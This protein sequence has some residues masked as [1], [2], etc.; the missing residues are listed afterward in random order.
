MGRRECRPFFY[1]EIMF[2][3]RRQNI[4]PRFEK[5]DKHPS[6]AD[7]I[8]RRDVEAESDSE[9]VSRL[10]YEAFRQYFYVN[11]ILDAVA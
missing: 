5:T 10:G 2:F 7:C 11:D 9:I 3:R 1:G 6:I 8:A 4:Q